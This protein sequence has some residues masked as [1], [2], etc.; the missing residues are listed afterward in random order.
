MNK[1]LF[2][3][4]LG[5]GLA[6]LVFGIITAGMDKNQD[7]DPAGIVEIIESNIRK[8]LV[9]AEVLIET[10]KQTRKEDS[11]FRFS[12]LV[13]DGSLPHYIYEDGEPIF[14]SD[15]RYVPDYRFLDGEYDLALLRTEKGLFLVRREILDKPSVELIV[16]IEL[17]HFS[18]ISN[19]YVSS[20]INA[21]IFPVRDIEISDNLESGDYNICLDESTC[22]FS[23]SFTLP[24]AMASDSLKRWS[25]ILISLAL[26]LL[27]YILLMTSWYAGMNLG[28]YLGLVVLVFSLVIVRITMLTFNFP[29]VITH[30]ELFDSRFFASSALN[31]SLGDL[32]IN[33]IFLLIVVIYLFRMGTKSK[34]LVGLLK[35]KPWVK[36]LAGG[37]FMGL[38][39]TTLL[40]LFLVFQNIYHNSQISFDITESLNLSFL[41]VV[42]FSIFVITGLIFFLFSHIGYR[43]VH[44][45][46]EGR[47]KY[48][49][50][51]LAIGALFFAIVNLL[52]GQNFILIMVVG[53][54]YLAL[55]M[56]LDMARQLARITYRSFLYAFSGAIFC[57]LIGAYA[58]FH[59]ERERI[60]DEKKKFANHFL[61]ENDDFAEYLLE[62]ASDQIKKDVFINNRIASPFSSKDAIADKIRQVY[63]NAY[64][65]KFDVRIYIFDGDGQSI[66]PGIAPGTYQNLKIQY[67]HQNF[68]T[69]YPNLFFINNYG[70]EISK[71]YLK[72]ISLEK[73]SLNTGY[74]A[75]DLRLKRVIPEN[76]YPELLVDSRFFMPYRQM[77]YSYAVIQQNSV[78]Y[79]SGDFNYL[80]KFESDFL[81]QG[82]LFRDGIH[83]E[84]FH[85]V[86]LLDLS[87]NFII[88]STPQYS[89]YSIISNFSFLFLMLVFFMAL[90]VSVYAVVFAIQRKT[91]NY[92]A[93]I[94]LYLNLAFF[95]PLLIVS[96]VTL[97][98][99]NRSFAKDLNED[100]LKVAESIAKNLSEELGP[101]YQ[102]PSYY[103]NILQNKLSQASRYAGIDGNLF[104]S[105]GELIATS[106]PLI[107]E[108]K[109][110]ASFINPA[111]YISIKE[112]GNRALVLQE[113][114]GN[115]SFNSTYLGI[116]SFDTGNY[117]GILSLP[118]FHSENYIESQQIEVVSNIMVIFTFIFLAFLIL[119]FF[120]SKWLTFPLQ[121]ITSKLKKT[122]L[123][124]FN[125]RLSWDSDDE[126]GLMVGEYNRMVDNLEDSRKALSRTEKETAWREIAKQVAHEIKNPL[127]PM[128]LTLQ[129]LSRI[130]KNNG[131]EENLKKPINTLLVQI[132]SLDGIA[133]SFSSFAKMP[134]PEHE[135]YEFVEIL[136]ST[137][138][139]Y[140]N[141]E[142]LIINSEIPSEEVWV[143]GD[144]KLTGRIISNI[145][146][147]ASQSSADKS[148][149]VTISVVLMIQ[150]KNKLVLQVKDDGDG[151]DNSIVN[152]VF[153][154]NFSTKTTGSGIG[155]TIA[156][157]GVEHAGGKIWFETEKGV[158]TSF[159]IEL[160]RVG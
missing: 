21:D 132:D 99:L 147:N 153:V 102:N 16:L 89:N 124:G 63:L 90:V 139:L 109:L 123:S 116:K 92:S 143:M 11:V 35:S 120:A 131:N 44:Q 14:W 101:F 47:F 106:Q 159:F 83:H 52:I 38:S 3:I 67:D 43:W 45:L 62:D 107:Y 145:L 114:V 105:K 1:K 122:T 86:G 95:L 64:F 56:A 152:K 87:G 34:M 136:K 115:L 94:Q 5:V 96:V 51:D 78:L 59:F 79:S 32:W 82:R 148:R 75:L 60:V 12:D 149:P 125:E 28:A 65:E 141:N 10:I 108:N 126:I 53:V 2:H 157:H 70:G 20:G 9:D 6:L 48:M 134:I 103:R 24:I 158:G 31:P 36:H 25:L 46:Y 19:K 33:L 117:I 98:L 8:E 29:N 135:R 61:I 4:I 17:A 84:G 68:R 104:N 119:S 77:S 85:H 26:V 127:T 22:F 27:F 91:L 76:V 72:L 133:T 80:K 97:S 30:T 71:R 129:Q 39:I 13:F 138:D 37:L 130:I 121:L 128:K 49:L 40:F 111:A 140:Q 113:S 110:L 41:R 15:Y 146:I 93:R 81:K 160:P 144:K 23:V 100:Y 58:I 74:I 154:P 156:K 73:Y 112:E 155:L 118:F 42:C 150:G 66:Q 55:I 7:R 18:K 57:S 151:I 50:I 88:V 54:F 137:L 142:Q 69:D